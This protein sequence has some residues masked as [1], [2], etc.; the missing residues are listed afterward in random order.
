MKKDNKIIFHIDVNSAYLSWISVYNL[1]HGD[2]LDL[3]N[4]PSAVGGDP[5][6]RHGIILAKSVPAKKYGIQTG[7]TL[8]SARQKCPELV[9]VPPRYDLFLQSSNAMVEIFREY[10]P[11]IQRYSVDECF[12][13]MAG[14]ESLHGDYLE[15]AKKISERIRGELG[16][17]VNI[18]ISNNKL[19]A[20]VASDL[21]KPDKIHTLF[22]QEIEKKMWPLPVEDLFMVGRATLPKLHKLNIYTIGDL[23]KHDPN[24]L[25]SILK[26]HGLLIWNYANGIEDSEVR[27]SNFIEMKGI[28][29]STTISFDVTDR[30]I[31][32]MVL[33]S[34]CE[35]VGMRLRNSGNC[36]RLVS[37][38]VK[39]NSFFTSSHQ[40][41]LSFAVDSTRAIAE[42]AYELF[43]DLWRGE[44]LR[45]IGVSIS[46]LCTN[47]FHQLSLFEDKNTEKI[48]QLDSAMDSIR[49][50]Y[51]S[52]SIVRSV[53]LNSEVRPMMGG[54][55][56][57]QYPI[58]TSIL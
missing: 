48:R 19:L 2:S 18:G 56:E 30:R 51:G 57:D 55:G 45:H 47:E 33:L 54:V 40:R 6:S 42:I 26:S 11:Q 13:D 16:F 1:Q 9:I 39:T 10:T 29:N 32:H 14:T 4:I 50:K 49:L 53:F 37:V 17:T 25:K 41:K 5:T 44:P 3:R 22:P 46:E 23:A 36:C 8:F 31:A 20:K 24:V 34:L 38:S 7:E 35:T 27:K 52:K 58:M 28:G 12:L 43:D 21:E 15:T